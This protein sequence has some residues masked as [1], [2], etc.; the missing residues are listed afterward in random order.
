[1]PIN[2]LVVL[3]LCND[4]EPDGL[5]MGAPYNTPIAARLIAPTPTHRTHLRP[6]SIASTSVSADA[7]PSSIFL[8]A[9]TRLTTSRSYEGLFQVHCPPLRE[10]LSKRST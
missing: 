10:Y 7:I 9:L 8:S 2:P 6:A 4:P 5:E 3:Y 1:M